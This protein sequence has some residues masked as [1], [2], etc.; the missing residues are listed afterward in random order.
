MNI[1]GR[2]VTASLRDPLNLHSRTGHQMC[3][4][5]VSLEEGVVGGEDG[6]KWGAERVRRQRGGRALGPKVG[7][8][9]ADS[10]YP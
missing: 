10:C 3:I 4:R 9:L 8:W 1:G 7:R 2:A 5:G 6:K